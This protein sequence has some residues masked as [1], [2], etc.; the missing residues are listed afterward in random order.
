MEGKGE[1]EVGR[2]GGRERERERE[3]E[4]KNPTL[5]SPGNHNDHVVMTTLPTIGSDS[6]NLSP[7]GLKRQTKRVLTNKATTHIRSYARKW[8]NNLLCVMVMFLLLRRRA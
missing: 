5:I 6:V 1:R 7:Q 2:E 8:T 3:R 4:I